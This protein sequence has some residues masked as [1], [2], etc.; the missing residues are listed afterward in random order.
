MQK[1]KDIHRDPRFAKKVWITVGITAFVAI[2]IL[3]I[4]KTF[5][6]FLLLLAASLIALFFNAVSSKIKA[7]TGLKDGVSLAVTIILMFLLAS[8]DR[9]SVV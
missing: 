2:M 8:L 4:Y 1:E 6:V 9:K 7:W 5:N 3:I